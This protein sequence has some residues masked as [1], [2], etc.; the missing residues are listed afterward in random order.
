MTLLRLKAKSIVNTAK[1]ES[2]EKKDR[3]YFELVPESEHFFQFF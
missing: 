1:Y 2:S 3:I